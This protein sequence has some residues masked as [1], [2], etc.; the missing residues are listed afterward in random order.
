MANRLIKH[1]LKAFLIIVIFLMAVG[2][3]CYSFLNY[4]FL[5][6]KG[7]AIVV[8]QMEDALG[9]KVNIGSL[10]WE[11]GDGLVAHDVT[12]SRKTGEGEFFNADSIA[13]KYQLVSIFKERFT[14]SSMHVRQPAVVLTRNSEGEWNIEDLIKRRDEEMRIEFAKILLSGATISVSD[15][16]GMLDGIEVDDVKFLMLR[17]KTGKMFYLSGVSSID[18][19]RFNMS[20]KTGAGGQSP[21][22]Q[23]KLDNFLVNDYIARFE[24][25]STLV[26]GDGPQ[27]LKIDSRKEGAK[28]ISK[29]RLHTDNFF[30][31]DRNDFWYYRGGVGATAT[32]EIDPSNIAGIKYD[33]SII[34]LGGDFYI[35]SLD[36]KFTE[37]HGRLAL[38]NDKLTGDNIQARWHDAKG[39]TSFTI[40]DFKAGYINLQADVEGPTATLT[41]FS[42]DVAKAIEGLSFEGNA[43]ADITVTGLLDE[44][45][46]DITVDGLAV[47]NVIEYDEL[48]LPITDAEVSIYVFN[49]QVNIRYLA[50]VYNNTEF[51]C[52]ADLDVGD[53]TV[54]VKTDFASGDMEA[55]VYGTFTNADPTFYEL[56]ITVDGDL[57]RLVKFFPIAAAKPFE[58]V[59]AGGEIS[60]QIYT[61][62]NFIDPTVIEARG[63]II[64]PELFI[65]KVP[66]KNFKGSLY[67]S[68]GIFKLYD[69]ESEIFSGK[70]K[71]LGEID[72]SDTPAKYKLEADLSRVDISHLPEVLSDIEKDIEGLLSGNIILNGVAE[73]RSA[74][75]GKGKLKIKDAHL[76]EIKVFDVFFQLIKVRIPII[77][78]VVFNRVECTFEIVDESVITRDLHF[79]SPTLD[80]A[81]IGKIGFNGDLKFDIDVKLFRKKGNKIIAPI[82]YILEIP[83]RIIPRIFLRGTTK[84]PKFRWR[85]IPRIPILDEMFRRKPV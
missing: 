23:L 27:D 10:R 75:T 45:T 3:L 21:E 14:I 59:S 66:I 35:L 11:I 78:R 54:S 36:R 41:S 5:P 63:V 18:G 70:A 52:V 15:S 31:G 56:D 55:T 29:V 58:D 61:V 60:T 62:G 85:P 46:Q 30:I 1:S 2:I 73:N 47:N 84:D 68:D 43:D 82:K 48:D 22:V 20:V 67:L 65:R 51:V 32:I 79:S 9:R 39:T 72:F 80:L 53:D 26:F 83:T 25:E 38:V 7:R 40:T 42:N 33:S 77:G 81:T 44:G 13:L 16:T 34:P 28:W 64:S 12:V 74:M 50:G 4:Y 6:Q 76:W 8:D 24:P 19:M 57:G 37:C 17:Q 71:V 49:D 69:T